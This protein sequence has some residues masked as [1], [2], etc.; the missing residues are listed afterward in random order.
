MGLSLKVE[1][2]LRDAGLIEFFEQ[3]ET[4][5]EA[6]AKESY[7]YV[8]RNFPSDATIRRDDVSD[9]LLPLLEVHESLKNYL[10]EKHLPQ[11]YWFRFFADLIVDRKWDKITTIEQEH[12]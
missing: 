1:Q 10:K 5:W 2:W 8:K 7:A 3:D 12:Q 4:P 9:A 6:L 11:K